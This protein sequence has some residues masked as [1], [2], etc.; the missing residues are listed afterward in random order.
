MLCCSLIGIC[1]CSK[2]LDQEPITE[3]V[4]NNFLTNEK[5]TEEYVNSVYASLQ[6]T[7]LYGLYLPALA[8]IPS[9]NSFDEVPAN[10]SGIFGDLD[11]FKTIS[12]NDI[13]EKNWSDSYVTIQR[14][15]VVINRINN[16]PYA[17]ATTRNVRKGEVE[18]IRALVYFNLIRLYGDVPLATTET[19]NPNQYFGKGRTPV[20]QVYQQII[21]DLKDA[22]DNLPAVAAQPGRVIKTAAQTLLGKV[23]LTQG[24]YRLAKEQ[25]DAVIASNVHGLVPIETLFDLNNENNKEIIFSVQFASGINGNT[26]GSVMYQQFSPSGTVDGAKGHNLP[27]KELYNLYSSSDKRKTVYVGITTNGVPFNNKLKRPGNIVDGGSDFVVLRYADVLLMKAEIEN[28]LDNILAVAD[29]LNMVRNRAGLLNT[30]A[31]TKAALSAAIEQERRL[32][33]VGEADRW[34]DLLKNGNAVTT[35]N[36]WFTAQHIPISITEK[37]LKLPIP[38]SQIN[39]DPSIKQN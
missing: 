4:I 38:Q 21:T 12:T 25:V 16:I 35:M 33:L 7:G 39:T 24:N 22:I 9:D 36:A 23:Y 15:N 8:E 2:Q 10:D 31:I 5:E 26:E 17:S 27:T 14:A 18:F 6:S 19:T 20:D 30:T 13:L 37:N 34:F 1:S 29:P 11:Q 28:K 32:E 3:K